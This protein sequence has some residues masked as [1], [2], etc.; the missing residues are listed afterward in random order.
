MTDEQLERQKSKDM[1]LSIETFETF[2]KASTSQNKTETKQ[3]KINK[4]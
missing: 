2:L 4:L 3:Q 1:Y